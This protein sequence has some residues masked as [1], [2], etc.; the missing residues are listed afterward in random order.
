MKARDDVCGDQQLRRFLTTEHTDHTEKIKRRI[1]PAEKIIPRDSIQSGNVFVIFRLQFSPSV[2]SVC[3]VVKSLF[4][5]SSVERDAVDISVRFPELEFNRSTSAQ[6]F[7]FVA[8]FPKAL[9]SYP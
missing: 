8:A 9:R 4:L 2:W 3:S 7:F 5:L 6:V 1:S